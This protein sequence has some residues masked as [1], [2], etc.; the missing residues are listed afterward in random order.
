MQKS[1]FLTTVIGIGLLESA[2]YACQCGTVPDALRGLATSPIVLEV[3]IQSRW[4]VQYRDKHFGYLQLA[5]TFDGSVT[6]TL[7]GPHP[8]RVTFADALETSA[9]GPAGCCSARRTP[10]AG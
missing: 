9:F 1:W 8:T 10:A 4:V 6:R 5:R 2:A 7:K 3:R